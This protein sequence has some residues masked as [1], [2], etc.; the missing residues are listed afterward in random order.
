MDKTCKAISVKRAHEK[1]TKVAENIE[2][3]NAVCILLRVIPKP[4]D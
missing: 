4:S 2:E 1:L 3:D